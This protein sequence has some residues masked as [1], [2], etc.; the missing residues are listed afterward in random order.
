MNTSPEQLI[1][2][3]Q[4]KLTRIIE[5]IRSLKA[6]SEWSTL[7]TE[8]FDTLVESLEKDLREEAKKDNPD[9]NKLNRIS[10]ELQWA[11]RYSDLDKWENALRVELTRINRRLHET[12]E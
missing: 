11:E 5:T 12:N 3:R 9:T 6:S 7:K 8:V 4:V 1:L 10:G 2:E